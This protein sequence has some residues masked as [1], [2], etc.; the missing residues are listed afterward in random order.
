MYRRTVKPSCASSTMMSSS[1]VFR[2]T[3]LAPT[4]EVAP[5]RVI[6]W[7]TM[8]WTSVVAPAMR[9]SRVGAPRYAEYGV[10]ATAILAFS[11]CC[12]KVTRRRQYSGS[13]MLSASSVSTY[14]GSGMSRSDSPPL[15]GRRILPPAVSRMR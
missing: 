7:W 10:C 15:T 1:A 9:S 14:S 8:C 4:Q 6:P 13:S 5:K 11:G 12:M 2:S 3:A